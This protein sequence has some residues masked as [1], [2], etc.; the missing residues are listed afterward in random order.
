VLAKAFKLF[1]LFP[2][3][4]VWALR[5]CRAY[6]YAKSFQFF[7]KKITRQILHNMG[8]ALL[9]LPDLQIC[10]SAFPTTQTTTKHTRIQETG[11]RNQKILSLFKYIY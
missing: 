9:A 2:K 3:F 4:W 8:V 5:I 10:G 7:F 1:V 11:D 6:S